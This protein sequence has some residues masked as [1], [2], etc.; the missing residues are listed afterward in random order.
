LFNPPRRLSMS[1]EV[2]QHLPRWRRI[3]HDLAKEAGIKNFVNASNTE[4]SKPTENRDSSATENQ[5]EHGD[6]ER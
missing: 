5:T 4:T 1:E 6:N 2:Y 3:I